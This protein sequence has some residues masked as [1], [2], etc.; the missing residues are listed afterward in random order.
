MILREERTGLGFLAFTKNAFSTQVELAHGGRGQSYSYER[1]S[2]YSSARRGGVSRGSDFRGWYF[3]HMRKFLGA[4][5]TDSQVSF[6]ESCSYGY[7][8]TFIGIVA[9]SQGNFF[10]F[11]SSG[12]FAR[13]NSFN[14]FQDHM[15]RAGDV[16]FSDVYR[17]AVG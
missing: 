6:P 9:R 16:C 10:K 17:V 13:K 2:S 4:P 11:T 15:R 7:W 5:C 1:S 12:T 14:T 3:C 8:F